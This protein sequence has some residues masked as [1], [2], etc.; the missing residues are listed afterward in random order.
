MPAYERIVIGEALQN[1]DF[2]WKWMD[3]LRPEHFTIPRMGRIW[4]ALIKA[5]GAGRKPQKTWVPLY[6]DPIDS[7]EDVSLNLELNL[8]INDLEEGREADQCAETVFSLANKRAVLDAM[9]VAHNR[10]LNSDISTTPEQMQGLAMRAVATSID[11]GQEA[12]QQTH[13]V[14]ARRF[15]D[16]VARIV[17]AG[18]ES[19]GMGLSTG[20]RGVDEV[21]GR[22]L[23]GKAIGLAG[24]SGSGKSALALQI[25]EAGI[26]EAQERGLGAGYVGSLEMTGQEY[27][28]RSISKRMGVPFEELERGS[29][30]R[31]QLD[32]LYGHMKQTEKYNIVVDDTP[33]QSIDQMLA[34]MRKIKLT[35]GLSIAVVDHLLILGAEKGE[36]L[37]EKVSNASMKIKNGAKELNIPIVFLCQLTEKKILE[38]ASGWPNASHLF[39]GETITQN[40]DTIAFVHRHELVLSKKE[41]APETEAHAKW[42]KR[43]DSY[44]DKA[45]FF[46]DKRRGGARQTTRELRFI[47]PT[48]HFEDI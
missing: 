6:I 23:P 36:N 8:L 29:I 47:G 42:V 25:M 27:A 40:A 13:A 3:R 15:Y 12:H 22:L 14:W 48:M 24:M 18:E 4:D 41:P 21:L 2:Y 11:H 34:Q 19:G 17:D 32:A 46:N 38:T 33:N 20:L 16:Q 45:H 30:D 9:V 43:M 28:I 7:K 26:L 35:K 1:S 39:G 44:R 31:A 37:F 10:I 5:T